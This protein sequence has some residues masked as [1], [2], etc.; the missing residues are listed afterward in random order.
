MRGVRSPWLPAATALLAVGAVLL[1]HGLDA[2]AAP[3]GTP[4]AAH[5]HDHHADGDCPDCGMVHV[6]VACLAVVGLA[7][8]AVHRSGRA[9][10][11]SPVD[12]PVGPASPFDVVPRRP[13]RWVE[14]S[15]MRC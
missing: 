2:H 4:A 1:M 9:P 6:L 15:V 11:W 8:A 10:R 3:T 7:V 13:P 12:L 14:L 5:E